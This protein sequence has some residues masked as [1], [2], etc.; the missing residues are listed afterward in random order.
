MTTQECSTRTP[1]IWKCPEPVTP[2]SRNL[3]VCIDGT[4]N[5][6]GIKNTN[7]VELY[8]HIKKDDR[9]LTYYSSGLGTIAKAA[10]ASLGHR[11]S[12]GLDMLFGRKLQQVIMASYRWLSDNYQDGDKIFLFGYSRGAYQVRALAGMIS[13]VGLLRPGNDE[14][15]PF[16]FDLY[17]KTGD[18]DSILPRPASVISQPVTRESTKKADYGVLAETF[19]E[20]FC[21]KDVHVHFVGVWDTVSAVGL[22]RNK[23]LPCTTSSC[24]HICYFRHALALDERRV[25]FLPEYVYGGRSNICGDGRIKEVW[26]AGCHSDVGGGNRRNEKLQSGDVPLLWMRS[27]AIAA[28]LEMKPADVMWKIDDLNKLIT[29]SLTVWWWPLEVLPLKRLLYYNSNRHTSRP[30]LGEPRKILPGQ[31]VHVSALFKNNYKPSA[32]FFN[33]PVG[34]PEPMF[35][36]DPASHQRL[37]ELTDVWEKDIFDETSIRTLLDDLKEG[38]SNPD[39][40]LDQLAFMANFDVGKHAILARPN[41]KEILADFLENRD[42]VIRLSTAAIYCELN[43][44]LEASHGNLVQQVSDDVSELLKNEQHRRRAC[45]YLPSLCKR[46]DWKAGLISE[47]NLKMLVQFCDNTRIVRNEEGTSTIAF[48]GAQALAM[49][50]KLDPDVAERLIKIDRVTDITQALHSNCKPVLVAVL[51]IVDGL[52]QHK[53]GRTT[54]KAGPIVA[55]LLKLVKQFDDFVAP[56][57]IRVLCSLLSEDELRTAMLQFGVLSIFLDML[58]SCSEETKQVVRD[59]LVTFVKYGDV[60]ATLSEDGYLQKLAKQAHSHVPSKRDGA[61]IA[62]VTLGNAEVKSDVMNAINGAKTIQVLVGQLKQKATALSAAS[63]LARLVELGDVAVILS[64]ETSGAS[65]SIVGMLREQWFDGL[66]GEDG[67]Q[68]LS[69]LLECEQLRSAVLKADAI[70]VLRGMID[71][72]RYGRTYAALH[73][74]RVIASFGGPPFLPLSVSSK[75]EDGAERVHP[76]SDMEELVRRVVNALRVPRRRVQRIAVELLRLLSARADLRAVMVTSLLNVLN[77]DRQAGVVDAVSTVLGFLAT[78]K[79]IRE[80][81]LT[82]DAFW[83]LSHDYYDGL[84]RLEYDNKGRGP[85]KAEVYASVGR[86]IRLMQAHEGDEPTGAQSERAGTHAEDRWL[87]PVSYELTQNRWQGMYWV[88]AAIRSPSL[89]QRVYRDLWQEG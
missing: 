14:Q 41:A 72:T 89:L 27:Q 71:P 75:D 11:A 10:G 38:K 28:G 35:W 65:V 33:N 37:R 80:K 88:A 69:E 2:S 44:P 70:D 58:D 8:S 76:S 78:D 56:A 59:A 6:F 48:N 39:A 18:E 13:R 47:D 85:H 57:A 50:M 26:F 12:N 16:A 61:I 19:Q 64:S 45:M 21:R 42:R 15:I 60:Q 24:D 46:E 87:E 32:Q 73:Y 22:G 4:S 51:N 66:R 49:L 25:K 1:R 31:K 79:A 20:T 82:E 7:I 34:W 81:V 63:A 77:N 62:L 55:T 3:V 23:T 17:S 86:M 74:L 43:W 30:H 53:N 52:A 84:S 83:N 9:Q 36:N 54:M 29:P 68:V 67:L 40:A 5:Q